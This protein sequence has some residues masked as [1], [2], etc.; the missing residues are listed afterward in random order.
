[1]GSMP[2]A[3]RAGMM[4]ASAATTMRTAILS[5]H[6]RIARSSLDPAP[7]QAIQTE[8]KGESRNDSDSHASSGREANEAEHVAATRSE[9]DANAEFARPLQDGVGDNAVEAHRG[10]VSARKANAPKRIEMSRARCKF[11]FVLDPALKV[12]DID[13]R[14]AGPDR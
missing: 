12:T 6:D 4:Q 3:R 2:V 7:D 9:S 10:E 8:T 14:P 13:L 11:R 1:M 5:D